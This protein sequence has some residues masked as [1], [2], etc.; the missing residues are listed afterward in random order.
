MNRQKTLLLWAFILSGLFSAQLYAENTP[1]EC[2]EF[3]SPPQIDGKL[4][5]WKNILP[6][7]LIPDQAHVVVGNNKY[8]GSKDLSGKV[9]LGWDRNN[10][11]IALKITDDIINQTIRGKNLYQG[12]HVE[13][14]I[15]TDITDTAT[16]IFN[17]DDF[18]IGL[19]PGNLAGTGDFLLDIDP[20]AFIW[21]PAS[22]VN[23]TPEIKIAS[24]RT[25]DGYII[26]AAVPFSVLGIKPAKEVKFR[27]DVCIS[28]TDE[29]DG[30]QETVTSLSTKKWKLRDTSRQKY[31]VLK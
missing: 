7:N 4:E 14:F 23:K 8:N 11:Y 19:S 30:Q 3:K 6:V 2:K 12:D 26:E 31:I 1:I 9:F 17:E 28:D 20:E 24:S 25:A 13:L 21:T 18:Q 5:E 27:L 15:D 22:K 10:L 16:T 29:L